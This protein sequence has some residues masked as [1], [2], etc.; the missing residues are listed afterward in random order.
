MTIPRALAPP[1][2]TGLWL[3]GVS[4]Y[5]GQ[6]R[7][8]RRR[9]KERHMPRSPAPSMPPDG[10]S[11]PVRAEVDIAD[12]RALT[13]ALRQDQAARWDALGEYLRHLPVITRD[14]FALMTCLMQDI[15]A[16]IE[17]G[18]SQRQTQTPPPV[19]E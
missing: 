2:A 14:Q 17:A 16:L 5:D 6:T 10:D 15:N 13:A 12:Q 11:R 18:R 4:A 9:E 19:A 7:P 1:G 8:P 3:C